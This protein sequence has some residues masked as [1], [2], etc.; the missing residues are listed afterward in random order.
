MS[1]PAFSGTTRYENGLEMGHA[2]R[3]ESEMRPNYS[4]AME[5]EYECGPGRERGTTE[6]A[7]VV[8]RGAREGI[9]QFGSVLRSTAKEAQ[10]GSCSW[11]LLR[12]GRA[13]G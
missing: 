12:A 8:R 10:H 6:C 1:H 11:L 2:G 9:S 13:Q 7:L 4:G 3:A 5:P